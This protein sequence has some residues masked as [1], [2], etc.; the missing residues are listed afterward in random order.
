[1]ARLIFSLGTWT[2]SFDVFEL[3]HRDP[4]I[5]VDSECVKRIYLA[6]TL[7]WYVRSPLDFSFNLC[8]RAN[9]HYFQIPFRTTVNQIMKYI[10]DQSKSALQ[11]SSVTAIWYNHNKNREYSQWLVQLIEGWSMLRCWQVI[12]TCPSHKKWLH[13]TGNFA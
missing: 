10:L 13:C 6:I 7:R 5:C 1:M 2:G 12:L 3:F 9:V 11:Q 4:K 8:E